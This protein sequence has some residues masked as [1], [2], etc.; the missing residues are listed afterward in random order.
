MRVKFYKAARAASPSYSA[1]SINA[2]I[3]SGFGESD[4]PF[5]VAKYDYVVAFCDTLWN[6]GGITI[7]S[8]FLPFQS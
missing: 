5:S 6:A 8:L 4:A 2:L 1:T 7:N 3:S